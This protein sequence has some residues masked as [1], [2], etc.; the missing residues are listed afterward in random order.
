MLI[1]I[2]LLLE[3]MIIMSLRVDIVVSVYLELPRRW[4]PYR[5][6]PVTLVVAGDFYIVNSLSKDFS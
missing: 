4:F 2:E 3:S 5:L 1:T 6:L